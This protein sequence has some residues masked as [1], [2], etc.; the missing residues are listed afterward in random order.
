MFYLYNLKKTEIAFYQYI[1]RFWEAR[2]MSLYSL[3]LQSDLSSVY[4][5]PFS[6]TL[7]MVN[8]AYLI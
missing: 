2:K 6:L 8:F 4:G 5:D 7:W 3:L 1:E